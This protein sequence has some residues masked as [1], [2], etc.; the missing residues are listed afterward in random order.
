MLARIGFDGYVG[1]RW[2][3]VDG[4]GKLAIWLPLEVDIKEGDGTVF[5]LFPGKLY[6]GDT[7]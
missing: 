6:S 1:V 3:S 7:G 5:F 2:L 4:G